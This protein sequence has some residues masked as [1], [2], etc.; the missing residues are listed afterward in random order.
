M[1][2][3]VTD[4]LTGDFRDPE[5]RLKW[6]SVDNPVFELDEGSLLPLPTPA[7][8]DVSLPYDVANLRNFSLAITGEVF[9]WIVEHGD[10][11][12]L[13]RMLVAGQIF[14][15]MSPDEKHEL[16]EKLQSINYCCSFC[17]D[18]ANDCGALKAADFLFIDLALILP[19]A[20]FS[21]PRMQTTK[22]FELTCE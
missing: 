16:V 15:R 1:V 12:I 8:S 6:Q 14:A 13:Q 21:K 22:I 7:S 4:L 3:M 10:E 20:I 19:I 11:R 17:G 5:A 9:R 2:V 18:G